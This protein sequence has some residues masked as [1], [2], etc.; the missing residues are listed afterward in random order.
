MELF[1]PIASADGKYPRRKIQLKL[2]EA[3][4]LDRKPSGDTKQT[5]LSAN[6][7]GVSAIGSCA[8]GP[9]HFFVPSRAMP[10]I[11]SFTAT[12][13]IP[14]WPMTGEDPVMPPVLRRHFRLPS[15][16]MA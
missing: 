4:R 11:L 12:K 6:A 15:R 7:K 1:T 9:A 13:I 16:L 5:E 14:S 3:S 8:G 2:P 10:Q